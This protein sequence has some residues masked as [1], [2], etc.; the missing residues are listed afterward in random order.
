[1]TRICEYATISP[2]AQS[3][4]INGVTQMKPNTAAIIAMLRRAEL[5]AYR[6]GK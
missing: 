2:G 1:L 4:I 5:A 6:R 3:T